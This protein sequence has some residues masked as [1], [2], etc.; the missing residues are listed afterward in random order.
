MLVLKHIGFNP[1][2]VSPCALR[3]SQPPRLAPCSHAGPEEPPTLLGRTGTLGCF[4]GASLPSQARLVSSSVYLEGLTTGSTG[5]R[6]FAPIQTLHFLCFANLRNSSATVNK[7]SVR[8]CR[9]L[10]RLFSTEW[11]H[12]RSKESETWY[13]NNAVAAKGLQL[14]FEQFCFLFLLPVLHGEK[15]KFRFRVHFSKITKCVVDILP[16]GGSLAGIARC[17][18][19]AKE[20]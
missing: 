11:K 13:Q 2:V 9:L 8:A 18:G 14:H 16:L 5:V 3:L 17:P 12:C 6:F 20:Q 7:L 10:T 4:Q 15:F 1:A 19:V